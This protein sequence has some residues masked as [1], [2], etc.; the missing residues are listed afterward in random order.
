[1]SDIGR[2][3]GHAPV[4]FIQILPRG[5]SAHA[6]V[7]KSR[8]RLLAGS[9]GASR[10]LVIVGLEALLRC[11]LKSTT[12]ILTKTKRSGHLSRAEAG[13]PRETRH[14]VAWPSPCQSAHPEEAGDR[15]ARRIRRMLGTF[16][17]LGEM[18][19]GFRVKYLLSPLVEPINLLVRLRRTHK[20]NKSLSTKS[21][22][23]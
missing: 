4:R 10:G 21:Q 8:A 11:M 22:Q 9:K 18:G 6:H 1:M 17:R 12:T 5:T 19:V 14:E 7:A 15:P 23:V 2:N 13:G 16:L 3:P 20:S